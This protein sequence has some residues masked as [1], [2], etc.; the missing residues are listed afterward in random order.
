MLRAIVVVIFAGLLVACGGPPKLDGSSQQAWKTSTS[1]LIASLPT[2]SDRREF[3]EAVF[4]LMGPSKSFELRTIDDAPP[5][6]QKKLN[7]FTALDTVKLHAREQLERTEKA[8]AE[9]TAE[10]EADEKALA[11]AQQKL[12]ALKIERARFY[13]QTNFI[14]QPVV[15]FSITNGGTEALSHIYLHGLLETPGRTIPWVSE[16]LNYKFAGGLE[17][18]ESKDLSLSPNMFGGWSNDETKGR[19]DLVLTLTVI[20]AD[21]ADEKKFVAIDADEIAEK[22]ASLTELA[23]ARDKAAAQA[24]KYP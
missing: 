17:P 5:E 6:L 7:G 24:A 1:A 21:G 15:A 3:Q 13:W 22:R 9:M 2:V 16:D 12:A 11:Q 23:S 8:L 19:K 10:V 4:G 20:N 18:G 14:A